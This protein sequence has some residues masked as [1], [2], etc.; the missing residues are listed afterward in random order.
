MRTGTI[1]RLDANA[2]YTATWYN[3]RT[4]EYTKINLSNINYYYNEY[5]VLFYTGVASTI[6]NGE[7]VIDHFEILMSEKYLRF[8]AFDFSQTLNHQSSK[9]YILVEDDQTYNDDIN[10]FTKSKLSL[11]EIKEEDFAYDNPNQYQEDYGGQYI[12]IAFYFYN[13]EINEYVKC[14]LVFNG[15]HKWDGHIKEHL[16]GD[17]FV[18][19]NGIEYH[20]EFKLY[21]YQNYRIEMYLYCPG[22]FSISHYYYVKVY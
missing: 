11:K 9:N 1:Q 12:E 4:N 18:D 7:S 19:M 16:Y 22:V 5:G 6:L 17:M 10:N 2:T 3:P 14:K 15:R 8:E 13:Y 21:L 20:F